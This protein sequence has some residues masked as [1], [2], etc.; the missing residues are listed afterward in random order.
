MRMR[1]PRAYAS[2]SNSSKSQPLATTARACPPA[3]APPPPRRS[4]ASRRSRRRR[5][6]ARRARCAPRPRA[7]RAR[8]AARSGGA[9]WR[10][11]SRGSRPRA[12]RR[13]RRAIA[14]PITC[15]ELGGEVESTT[16]MP[17]S[18]TMRVPARTRVGKPG[19]LGV[20]QQDA[21]AEQAPRA[22]RA[23]RDAVRRG[24]PR[25]RRLRVR[26]ARGS[27]RGAPSSP[28]GMSAARPGST[29]LHLGSSGASTSTSMPS[30]GRWRQSLST[31][32]T[33]PPPAGGK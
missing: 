32:C 4:T 21:A 19:D 33:P 28:A 15:T 16:S 5:A 23:P 24:E 14:A 17:R 7:W 31:R 29:A 9:D 27:A 13:V 30:S 12:A 11:R 1:S 25:G 3:R 10:A 20:G 26:R 8:C 18:R 6:A 22:R 2:P